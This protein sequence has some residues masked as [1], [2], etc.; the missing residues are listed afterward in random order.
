[1]IKNSSNKNKRVLVAMSGGVDSSVA[2]ALLLDQGYDVVGMT[3]QVWD[4]SNSQSDLV[5]S[6]RHAGAKEEGYGTCCSSVD[7]EDA[8]AVCRHLDIPF[9]VLNCEKPFKEQVIDRFMDAYL[10][11][12]TPVPCVDCNTY[13]KFGYLV[14]KM[15]ELECDYLATGHYAQVRQTPAGTYHIYK[16][17]DDWKDQTYFLFTTPENILSRLLFPVGDMDKQTVRKIADEKGLNVSHKKDST[18][19]CF[20]GSGGY[21]EFIRQKLGSDDSEQGLIRQYPSGEVLGQHRGLYHFTY[22]QRKGLGVSSNQTLYVVKIDAKHNTLWLGSE[23]YLYSDEIIVDNWNWLDKIDEGE[24]LKVK[25]R[26]HHKGVWARI[27][28]VNDKGYYMLKLE[29]PQ[30]AVTPG[31]A[32]VIYRGSQ[33][34]GGGRIVKN[35]EDI[36]G[37]CSEK[38]IGN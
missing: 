19:L 5:N 16:S 29:D 2:A 10:S 24:R 15:K 17:E 18:G 8:R 11:G 3:M 26:F 32:A 21:S 13:L 14:Q 38:H 36:I 23:S 12:K 35:A 34:V 33:L 27:Y 28:K 20:V 37:S 22:G 6:I 4:Y 30:K 31:Q 7:V 25:I 9:Y 1:M